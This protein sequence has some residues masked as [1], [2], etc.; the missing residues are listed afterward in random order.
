MYSQTYGTIP[1]VSRVGG[2]ND[3]VSESLDL[4]FKTGI[5]FEPGDSAS[6][7]YALERAKD[8]YYGPERDTIVQNCMNLNW[9]WKLRKKRVRRSIS[10]CNRRTFLIIC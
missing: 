6:L 10:N 5:V 7:G 4:K 1:I 3:T 9:S 8:I 2:L